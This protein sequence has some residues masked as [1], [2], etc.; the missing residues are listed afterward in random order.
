[1]ERTIRLLVVAGVSA[2]T[3]LTIDA[4]WFAVKYGWF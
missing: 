4:L 1:M 2:L 3:A